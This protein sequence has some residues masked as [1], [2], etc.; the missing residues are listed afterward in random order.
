MIIS[1]NIGM[2]ALRITES[3]MPL[4]K[5]ITGILCWMAK[6]VVLLKNKIVFS[7]SWMQFAIKNTKTF[8]NIEICIEVYPSLT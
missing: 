4:L 6:C 8:D 7:Y 2:M 5:L 3:A 1:T